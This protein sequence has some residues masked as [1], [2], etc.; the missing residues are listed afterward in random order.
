MSSGTGGTIGGVTSFL[1]QK[2]AELGRDP[3]D[4]GCYLIDPPGSGLHA[5]VT[6]GVFESSGSSIT[7]GIGIM[8]ETANF[9]RAKLDGAWQGSDRQVVEM[10]HYLLEKDGLFVG[11][12]AALNCVGAVKLARKLGPGKTVVTI[13]CDGGGRYQSRLFAEAWLAERDLVPNARARGLDFID[14]EPRVGGP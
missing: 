12:S 6:R 8:R 9:R 14:D 3:S 4:I 1:K 7:E 5:W 10:A 2:L 11:S 13:L